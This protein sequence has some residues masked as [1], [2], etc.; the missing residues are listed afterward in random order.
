MKKLPIGL[1]VYSIREEA[2]RNFKQAM[3]EVKDMGYDG[4]EL[5]GIYG[6]QPEDIKDW[7][8]EI[9]LIPIS[10]HVPYADLRYELEKTVKT[11]ATIGCS[12]IAIPYLVEDERYGTKAYEEFIQFLPRIAEEC[13]KYYIVLLYHNH[14]FEFLK[15]S[16]NEY[17]LDDLFQRLPVQELQAEIDTCWVKASNVDPTQYISQYKGRCP[18]IHL[19]DFTGVL[20]VEFTAIGQGVQDIKGILDAS[21]AAGAKWIIVEQDSHS[22][23]AP[24]E[25]TRLSIEFLKA[26]DGDRYE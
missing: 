17:V 6:H 3:K 16:T 23:N 12:Y 26:L 8:N 14:D 24:M 15:T 10:A 22:T 19:K 7:L 4:V 5:A 21:V 20:P 13:T 18:V 2:E 11:Y 9:G 1:Q 25:D